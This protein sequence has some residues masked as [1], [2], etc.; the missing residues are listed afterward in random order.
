MG[1]C[2]FRDDHHTP[3]LTVT[4]ENNLWACQ[5]KCNVGGSNL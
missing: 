4:P 1:R 2:P 5:G 3:S